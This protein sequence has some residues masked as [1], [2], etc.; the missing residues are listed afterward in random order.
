MLHRCFFLLLWTTCLLSRVS[1]ADTF[2][3]T[4]WVLDMNEGLAAARAEGKD[5]LVD[6]TGSDWCKVCVQLDSE[7]FGKQ[8][9]LAAAREDFVLVK[10]DY[11]E[12]GG[13]TWKT[14][15]REQH[16]ANDREKQA[17]AVNSFPTLY[18]MTPEGVAYART[19]YRPGGPQ[20][21]LR[22]LGQ[23]KTGEYREKAER[24]SD[25]FFGEGSPDAQRLSAAYNLLGRVPADVLDEVYGTIERL[26]P[27][28]S[29]GI[30]APRYLQDFA[31]EHLIDRPE[32]W[33]IPAA[34]LAELAG[35]FPS[36]NDQALYHYYATIIALNRGDIEGGQHGLAEM[37][38]IGGVRP[39]LIQML[40]QWLERAIDEAAAGELA[41]AETE[42]ETDS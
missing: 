29:R 22:H 4:D 27:T 9:F 18:L 14:M 11:P 7:V 36:V 35:R 2:S 31:S 20:A 28:D 13:A 12:P 30:L 37:E 26:D 6:F 24:T 32:N 34:A 33:E 23:L 16:L 10:L 19:G 25:H 40:E 41:E 1:A 39:D 17:F 21:F 8:E 5:I 42:T 3:T 38:R 15:A